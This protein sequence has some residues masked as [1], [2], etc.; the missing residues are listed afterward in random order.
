MYGPAAAFIQ[1]K[2]R[3]KA[4]KTEKIRFKNKLENYRV[5]IPSSDMC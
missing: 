2:I 5:K 4:D 1:R 3:R